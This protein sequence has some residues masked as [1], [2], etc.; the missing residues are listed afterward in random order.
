M[1]M[2]PG[3]PAAAMFRSSPDSP[4]ASG[5]GTEGSPPGLAGRGAWFASTYAR[6]G[7]D[8]GYT[9]YPQ[10]YKPPPQ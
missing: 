4:H 5:S 2:I 9:P 8:P 1:Q 7:V 6:G 10:A 3:P